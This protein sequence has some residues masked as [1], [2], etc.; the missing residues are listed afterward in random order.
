M[1]DTKGGSARETPNPR[2]IDLL[3]TMADDIIVI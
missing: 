2:R 1:K 3:E